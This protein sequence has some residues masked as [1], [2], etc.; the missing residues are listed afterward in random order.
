[1]IVGE[2]PG[3][4]EDLAGRPFVG[5]AGQLL[6]RAMAEAGL[7]RNTAYVTNAVKHFK[8]VQRGKRRLHS[9]PD[10]GEV[11]ACRWWL[12][13]ELA[14]IRPALTLAMGATAVRALFGKVLTVSR[15]RGAV[16]QLPGGEAALVTV[17]PSYLL[18]IRD[19]D[20]A[21]SEYRHF[22]ADLAQAATLAQQG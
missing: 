18:R 14:I 15:L 8:F 3:D 13:H 21:R 1:M 4:R 6:D 12:E 10:P 20:Q 7:E 2:Q 9:K 5:P 22:V 19:R 16:Q 11:E 17:H